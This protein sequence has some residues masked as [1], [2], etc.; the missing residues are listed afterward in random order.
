VR[1]LDALHLATAQYLVERR[2]PLAL[3]TYDERMR[4]C[5]T[6]LGL[7]LAET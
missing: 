2:Q 6:R 5:A 7:A 1:T 3:A 4:T